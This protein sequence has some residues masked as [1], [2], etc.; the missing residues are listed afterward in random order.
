MLKVF[1][2]IVK[3]FFNSTLIM[4]HFDF[5]Y[6]LFSLFKLSLDLWLTFSKQTDKL[7]VRYDMLF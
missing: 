3:L 4:L 5:V 7:R 2:T 1:L 6:F